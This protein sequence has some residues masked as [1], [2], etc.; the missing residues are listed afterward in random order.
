VID[1]FDVV[2]NL[3][4]SL[5]VMLMPTW[6]QLKV[7]GLGPV[8]RVAAVFE[9]GPP[10]AWLPFAKF[11]IKVLEKSD[12]FFL[13]IPNV[14]V[15][16][17]DGSPDWSSGLGSTVEAALEDALNYFVMSLDDHRDLPEKAFMWADPD[18]F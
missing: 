6:Q 8:S 4:L 2:D 12:G 18:D 7:E 14:C 16:G 17:L 1:L 15:K 11:K 13:A 9:I 5:K 10:L 3:S